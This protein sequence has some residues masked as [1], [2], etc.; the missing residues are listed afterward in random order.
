MG[1]IRNFQTV[2]EELFC[3]VSFLAS[4]CGALMLT[5]RAI[6]RRLAGEGAYLF[7]EVGVG[8]H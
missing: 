6:S 1:A 4:G 7:A 5:I 8:F 3:E 2:S